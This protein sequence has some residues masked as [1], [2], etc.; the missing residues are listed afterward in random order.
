MSLSRLKKN[1]EE[2]LQCLGIPHANFVIEHSQS[3][4]FTKNGKDEVEFLFAGNKGGQPAPINKV[5]SGGEIS[6]VMLSIKSLLSSS[7]RIANHY[8]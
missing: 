2:K 1:I 4:D 5:A 6:R 8:F 3:Q 7:K